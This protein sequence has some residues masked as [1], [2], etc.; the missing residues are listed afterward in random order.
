MA[1]HNGERFLSEQLS[2][3]LTE[4]GPDDEVIVVD[5]LS[6]DSSVA[7][8]TSFGDRRIRLLCNELNVGPVRSFERALAEARGDVLFLADQDDVWLPGKV[9]TLVDVLVSSGALAVVSD[10]IVIDQYGERLFDSFFA[11]RGSGPGYLRNL[12]KNGYL[13]CAMAVDARTKE[14][15]LPIPRAVAMHDEWI[16]LMCDLV[17]HVA[18]VREPLIAYRRHHANVSGMTPFPI[19]RGVAKRIRHLAL[20]LN[21]WLYHRLRR[22]ARNRRRHV[23]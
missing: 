17:G 2:S 23:S 20:T 15:V 13:G 14:F 21:R 4:L 16:G 19:H 5:D 1:V 12:R 6:T 8:V 11:L 9:G 3:I 22:M 18:F 7:I 10:A